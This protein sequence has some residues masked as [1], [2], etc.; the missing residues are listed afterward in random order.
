MP[1]PLN[2]TPNIH[3]EAAYKVADSGVR[4][5]AAVAFGRA[6]L[7]ML[8]LCSVGADGLLCLGFDL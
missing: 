1:A 8:L 6:I 3:G 4:R 7:Q 2:V 5:A